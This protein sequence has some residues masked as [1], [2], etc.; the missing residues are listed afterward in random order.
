MLLDLQD[1]ASRSFKCTR[2][3]LRG[4]CVAAT[5]FLLFAVVNNLIVVANAITM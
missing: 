1:R 5:G 4:A 3:M 2:V